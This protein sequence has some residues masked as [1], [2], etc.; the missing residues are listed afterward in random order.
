[1]TDEVIYK[2]KLQYNYLNFYDGKQLDCDYKP[3]LGSLYQPSINVID[4]NYSF[5]F[6]Y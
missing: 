5:I 6:I 1:M 3:C 4:Y 2:E